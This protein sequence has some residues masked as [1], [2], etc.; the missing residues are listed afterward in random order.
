MQPLSI[1]VRQYGMP[2]GIDENIRHSLSLGLPELQIGLLK[3]DG[4]A[5]IV[6]SGPSVKNHLEEIRQEQEKGRP[7]LAVK[8]AYDFLRKHDITPDL[9]CSVEPR[10]RPIEKPSKRSAYLLASRVNRQLFDDLK[11]YSVYL[12]HSWSDE[13]SMGMLKHKFCIGGGSTSGLRAINVL[14]LLGFRK[15]RLYGF[16]S[17]LGERGEK[18]VDQDPLGDEVKRI[19]VI[20]GGRRFVCNMAMAAQA[21]DFQHIYS[22]MPDLSMETIGS[23]LIPAILDERRKQGLPT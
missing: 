20:V 1:D 6:A 5:V 4:A 7:V 23:G 22:V 3:H 9:Y 12:W 19:D 11:G 8:G 14:Y 21:Q 17:C 13:D 10:Y 15:L 18:R 16:D 2:E